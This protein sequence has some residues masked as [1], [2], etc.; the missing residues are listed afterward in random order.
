MQKI[1]LGKCC[2]LFELRRVAICYYSTSKFRK[3]SNSSLSELACEA[4]VD[5]LAKSQISQTEIDAV[6][7]SSSTQETYT[8]SI[9]SEMLGIRPSIS[10]RIESLCNSGTNAIISAYSHIIS[11]LC[12][13]A[14][15]V[16]VEKSESPGNVLTWDI[17]R[18]SF[19]FPI[20]WA[21]MFAKAH[22]RKF[23]TTE[24][25]M[26]MV[27]VK[28]H[29]NAVNNPAAL[30]RKAVT[31]DG[32]MESKKIVPPIKILD[33]SAICEGASAVLIMSEDKVKS[34]GIEDPVWITGV[35]ME[36]RSASFAAVA[37]DLSAS[38]SVRNAAKKAFRM[39][40]KKPRDIDVAEVHDAFT[41]LEIMAYEDLGFVEKGKGGRFVDNCEIAFNPRGGILGSGHP[42]GATGI[43]QVAEV[44]AQ[45]QGKAGKRQVKDCENGLVQNLA[46]AGTSATVMIMNK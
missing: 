32:V 22:M 4:C 11:G 5:I 34:F 2:Q 18:G 42:V 15:V 9:V 23:G 16:G 17:T 35:G 14:L 46:A 12:D 45:I 21:S 40:G 28:N 20:H 10:Q 25:Q 43:A 27:S 37:A 30:F 1:Q 44:A 24:E 38:E 19:A 31:L 26:A 29:R 39:S 33:C 8:S 7:V 41:I 13:S 6:L 36:T 3:R